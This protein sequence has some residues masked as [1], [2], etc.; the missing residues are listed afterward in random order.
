MGTNEVIL[1]VTLGI[2]IFT[3]WSKRRIYNKLLVP[4]FIIALLLHGFYGGFPG[5]AFSLWGTLIGL[6]LLLIPYFMGGMGAGDVKL[7]TVIGAFGGAQFVLTSFLIGAMIGGLIS[8]VFLIRRKEL[9]STLTHFILFLP[10][11]KKTQSLSEAVKDTRKEKFP[12]GI[13]IALGAFITMFV[14]SGV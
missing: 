14:P 1:G 4:A 3:D 6:M 2:A 10:L 7:L 8:V 5:L 13:A 11:L 9:R 12:Y